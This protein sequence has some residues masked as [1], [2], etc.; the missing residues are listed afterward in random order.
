MQIVCTGN[1]LE[2]ILYR[3]HSSLPKKKYTE[4]WQL[5][6][7]VGNFPPNE[8][9]ILTARDGHMAKCAGIMILLTSATDYVKFAFASNNNMHTV[10]RL[11]HASHKYPI[12]QA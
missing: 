4:M 7:N 6:S 11:A 3:E 2:W 10:F 1:A 8:H 9:L 12:H 5:N